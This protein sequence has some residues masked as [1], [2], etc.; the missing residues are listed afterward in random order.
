MSHTPGEYGQGEGV[1][2]NAAGL[3]AAAKGDLDALSREMDDRIAALRGRWQGQG[4]QAFFVLQQTWV[5]KQAV[6][7]NALR[8]FE[9][10]LLS[11]E[12]DNLATD[13]AQGA[14]FRQTAARLGS[15]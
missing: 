11:T 6:I 1:L 12:R 2:A 5:E 13:D 7:V 3:V 9:A 15:L 4:G 10:S 8:D 14:T